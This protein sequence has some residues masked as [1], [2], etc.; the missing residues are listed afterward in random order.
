ML[1]KIGLGFLCF[2]AVLA[3]GVFVMAS[4]LRPGVDVDAPLPAIAFTDLEGNPV[5]AADFRGKVV[6]L[7]F[8]QST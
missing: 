8:W 6:L 3:V 7:D 4:R 5:A 1:K 2:G